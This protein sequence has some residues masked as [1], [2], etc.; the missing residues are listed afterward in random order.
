MKE[1]KR[2]RRPT[3]HRKNPFE[4]SSSHQEYFVRVVKDRRNGTEHIIVELNKW[5][6]EGY[7]FRT[8]VELEVVIEKRNTVNKNNVKTVRDRNTTTDIVETGTDGDDDDE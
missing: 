1:S 7:K 6:A 5:F 2:P 3:M 8:V 4:K